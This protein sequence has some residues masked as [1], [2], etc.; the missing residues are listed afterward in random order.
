MSSDVQWE[1]TWEHAVCGASGE[2]M[3]EDENTA[4][5]GHDCDRDGPIIWSAEWYC[6]GCNA[7]GGVETID[8]EV[9]TWSAHDCDD[10]HEV[11]G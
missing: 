2:A 5:S 4:T 10:E 6:H 3:W 11:A 9:S 8:D 1:G 7:S